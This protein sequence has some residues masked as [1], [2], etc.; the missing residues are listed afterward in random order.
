MGIVVS[1]EARRQGRSHRGSARIER[2]RT[3]LYFDLSDPGTYLAAERAD[4][5][6]PGLTWVP[7]S[8]GALRG[9]LGTSAGR[10]DDDVAARATLLRMPLV[11]P[12]SHPEPRPAAM[13][14]A[15]YA[16]EQGRGA[17]FV[18]AA[19]RLAFCGGFDLDDPEVLA[20]AAAA[21][22]VG[23]RECL[24]A[25]GDAARDE[26]MASAAHRLVAAGAH[27]LPVVRVGRLLFAGEERLPAASAAWRDPA[28]L[29]VQA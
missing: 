8:L 7:A 14:A 26:E 25:A 28:P 22:G 13:R 15:A 24:A 21:A 27:C 5:L 12:E 20:E 11:W 17:P 19:S 10:S 18:L 1:L 29:R 9:A 2:A 6:F 4:R 23:L 16:A 3:A